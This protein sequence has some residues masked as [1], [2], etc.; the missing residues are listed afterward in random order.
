MLKCTL[1]DP[2][3]SYDLIIIG[4][5]INGAA[6]AH[7][8]AARGYRTALLE[9]ND[10][11]CGVTSRSTRLIHGG[12]R[13]L[14]HGH[15]GLVRESLREREALL[16]DFPHQVRPLAFLIPVYRE[17]SRAWWWIRIGLQAYDW[18]SR[19][20]LV[21]RHRQLSAA[22]TLHLE[23]GLAPAGL[24]AGFVYYD[25]Q[26]PYPERLALQMALDAE[27][28]GA[29]VRNHTE[30][31]GFLG[32]ARRVIG[33]R[34]RGG[35]E[36]GARVVVNAAGPWAD[37]VRSLL[38]GASARPLLTLVNG[39][40]LVTGLFPGAPSHAIYHE[41]SADRRPF[42]IVP[43]RD[44]WL[45]GTTETP[46]DG[47]PGRTLPTAQEVDYLIRETN[48]LFPRA[49]LS[50]AS[51]L[52]A[53]AG[54][55]PL[56]NSGAAAQAMSRDHAIWDHESEDGVSG[57]LTLVGGKLTTARAFAQEALDRVAAR[58]GPPGSP[59][60]PPI[61][62]EADS[63]PERLAAIYGRG[64]SAIVEL[65]RR[66]PDLERP[67][68]PGAPATAAE[69]VHAVQQE[70]AC[71]LAD[72]LLRRTGLAFGPGRGLD[73]APEAA[74]I[75]APLLGWDQA[76]T[77]QALTDYRAELDDTLCPGSAS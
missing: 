60:P 35:E 27:A 8:A 74:R 5:G 36:L 24:R 15:V 57:A 65:A 55:R 38:T 2:V 14:E 25:G 67:I 45:I 29:T 44:L 33:V 59:A 66:Q 20:S 17:D 48:L 63:M 21:G 23:P 53:Y 49:A 68:A 40:H 71:T 12:L 46:F 73:A 51:V 26:A 32:D 72:I 42:F 18:I 43:W 37:R 64:A 34:T 28:L 52:Y 61:R 58:L 19:S 76:T 30:V 54:P 70:K 13:Y 1:P 6:L 62:A 77:A 10:F 47:D 39:A 50:R 7:A 9:K 16:R 75:A 3:G 22:E 11:G 31:T 4:G 69:L 41:A 56:L